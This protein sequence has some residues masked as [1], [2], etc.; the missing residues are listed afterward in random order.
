MRL[1]LDRHEVHETSLAAADPNHSAKSRSSINPP[2]SGEAAP[3]ISRDFADCWNVFPGGRS[4]AVGAPTTSQAVI[5][6]KA[7]IHCSPP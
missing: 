2:D 5:P 7:G 6:A 1:R 3:P 4:W